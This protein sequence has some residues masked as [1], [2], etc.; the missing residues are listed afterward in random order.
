MIE[1]W[2]GIA[3]G[4]QVGRK[5]TRKSSGSSWILMIPRLGAKKNQISRFVISIEVRVECLYIKPAFD[6]QNF[7]SHFSIWRG[8]RFIRDNFV[9]LGPQTGTPGNS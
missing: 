1:E 2:V 5:A 7:Q 3:S 6:L 9:E 4:I 8:E